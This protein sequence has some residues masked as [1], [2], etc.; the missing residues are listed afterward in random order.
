MVEYSRLQQQ[1]AELEKRLQQVGLWQQEPI[2][3][4]ALASQQPFA[5]D[6]MRFEQW[7]QFIFIPR[8]GM[9]LEHRLPLPEA[10]SLTPYAE[11]VF[12]T[13]AEPTETIIELLRAIDEPFKAQ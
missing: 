6:S 3:P 9:L 13:Y 8:F 2:D 11:E 10:M 1:I 7:L 12:K 5:M 4:S